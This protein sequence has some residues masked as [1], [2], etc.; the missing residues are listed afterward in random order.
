[1][2]AS[3]EDAGLPPMSARERATFDRFVANYPTVQYAYIGFLSEHLADMSR[4][5]RGDLQLPL[6]L[7]VLGQRRLQWFIEAEREGAE[8]GWSPAMTV[9]RIADVTGV[10]RETARRKLAE[11]E[12]LGWIERGEGGWTLIMREGRARA[13]ADLADLDRRSLARAARLVTTLQSLL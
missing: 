3:D 7:A 13:R 1:M 10:P 4:A 9:M 6:V 2:T 5:F 11:L 8:P 12:R